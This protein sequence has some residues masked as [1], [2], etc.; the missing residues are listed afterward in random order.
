LPINPVT[1]ITL[2]VALD[3][4]A[5]WSAALEKARTAGELVPAAFRVQAAAAALNEVEDEVV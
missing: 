1:D 3:D 5:W 4:L 2:E